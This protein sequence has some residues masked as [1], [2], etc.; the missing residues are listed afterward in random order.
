M[1]YLGNIFFFKKTFNGIKML[2]KTGNVCLNFQMGLKRGNYDKLTGIYIYA[3]SEM[4]MA[5]YLNIY[6]TNL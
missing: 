4:F 1:M 5:K 3:L 2:K 6:C